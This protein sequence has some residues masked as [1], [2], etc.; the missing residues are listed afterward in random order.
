MSLAECPYMSGSSAISSHVQPSSHNLQMKSSFLSVQMGLLWCQ[1]NSCECPPRCSLCVFAYPK[2]DCCWCPENPF[3]HGGEYLDDMPSRVAQ[4][5]LMFGL[6]WLKIGRTDCG[7][8]V[9]W[10]CEKRIDGNSGICFAR[11]QL[12]ILRLGGQGMLRQSIPRPER[13]Y[14]RLAMPRQRK[15]WGNGFLSL[16]SNFRKIYE[17]ACYMGRICY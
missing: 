15:K 4:G 2:W 16:T 3:D 14:H 9:V 7:K 6:R 13:R 11:E 17:M 5:R 10:S 12:L 8:R 1:C